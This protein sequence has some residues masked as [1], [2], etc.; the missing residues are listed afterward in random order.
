MENRMIYSVT[1]I[2]ETPDSIILAAESLENAGWKRYDINTPYP[3]HGM[4]K[5]MNLRPSP[6]GY[7]ALALGLSGAALALFFL[8]FTMVIEYPLIIGGKPFFALPAFIPVT[9]EVTVLLASV[10]TVFGML[11]VLFKLPNNA[12][13]LH[14]SEYMKKCASDKFGV[15]IEAKDDNFEEAK[16]KDFLEKIGAKEIQTVYYDEAEISNK[17]GIFDIK[18]IVFLIIAA[19]FVS[20][21]S[22]VL[23]NKVSFMTPFDWMMEQ[24]RIDAQS[25]E[26][27]FSDGFGNRMP[28]ANAIAKGNIPYAFPDSAEFAGE[29]MAN[30]L[31]ATK[32]SIDNGKIKYDIYCSPCH[33]YIGTGESRLQGQF[34]N[35]PSLHSQKLRDWTDGQIYHVITVGQNSMPAYASQ[36]PVRERWEIVHYI[37]ALQRAMNAKEE[38]MK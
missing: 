35:P 17:P 4:P 30:P 1:G 21:A 36:V 25:P 2:F 32:E 26:D 14:D 29:Y 38:D 31:Q 33:D 18:F 16:A 7:F 8:T 34:P 3:I 11:F 28:P 6:L 37:R 13:P 23:L 19:A 20:G 9:F 12:H 22:Y 5:A 27:F 24:H 15:C 10:G